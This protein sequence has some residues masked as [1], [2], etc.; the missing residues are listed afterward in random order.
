MPAKTLLSA[1]F[2][3]LTFHCVGQDS[4]YIYTSA[5]N[6]YRETDSIA[7]TKV[8]NGDLRL[9][10]SELT[11]SYADNTYKA[12]AIFAWI[13][14]NIAYDY[15]AFNNHKHYKAPKCKTGD[16]CLK[17]IADWKEDYTDKV[18]RSGKSVC[19]GYAWLFKR[20]CDYAGLQTDFVPGYTKHSPDEVGRMGALD[21]AWNGI[22]LDG[23][24]YYLDVTWASGHCPKD[25][26]GKLKAFEKS[27]ND[28]YWLTPIE[29]FCQNH[30]PEDPKSPGV[31]N[32]SV[33]RYK[34]NPYII[35][36]YLEEIE[37]ILPSTG[38][39]TAKVGDTI[40]FAIQHKLGFWDLHF[41]TNTKHNPYIVANSKT[42]YKTLGFVTGEEQRTDQYSLP[43]KRKGDI[44]SFDFVVDNKNL[45]VIEFYMNGLLQLVFKVKVIK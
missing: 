10:V 2:L 1:L 40:N 15:K 19:D 44:Y 16:D 33:E 8:Y 4:T 35:N 18:L 31:A 3:F 20:M 13:A 32:Y 38:V 7:R 34:N 36:D 22:I 23:K 27:F 45:R 14:D 42:V 12:R 24:Y 26:K 9:L 5:K 39:V 25:K 29:K 28:F 11:D 41:S 17:V 43:F 6:T 37:V 30:Y 21:H